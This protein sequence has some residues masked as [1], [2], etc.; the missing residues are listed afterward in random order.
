MAIFSFFIY[1][2]SNR[3]MRVF[4]KRLFGFCIIL[5][6][7]YSALQAQDSCRISF[8]GKVLDVDH[9]EVLQGA[10]I[11]ID[12]L[13]KWAKTDEKGIFSFNDICAGKYK[14]RCTYIGYDTV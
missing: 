2:Q 5:F 3:N 14:V 1:F 13:Q 9:K 10:I 6:S 12:E 11:Y 7:G 8:T 4:I